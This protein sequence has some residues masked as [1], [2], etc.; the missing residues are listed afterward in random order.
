MELK[1]FLTDE[2]KRGIKEAQAENHFAWIGDV[3][4]FTWFEIKKNGKLYIYINNLWI[5]PECREHIPIFWIRKFLKEKYPNA[6][7]GY[8]ARYNPETKK[9]EWHYSK[10]SKR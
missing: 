10:R 6:E 2:V 1:E 9:D 4:F 8:W 5:K 3:G 7:Y